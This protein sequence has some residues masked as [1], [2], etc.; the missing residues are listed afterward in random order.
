[1]IQLR[2]CVRDRE[3]IAEALDDSSVEERCK[4]KLMAVRMHYLNLPHSSIAGTLNISDDAVTN[5]LKLYREGGIDALLEN[6]YYQPSSS[7]ESYLD[8][9]R[10][11]LDN[12]PVATTKEGA[13]RIEKLTGIKLSDDQ[14]RR[15]IKRLGLQYR[16]TAAVPEK[17]MD[18]CSLSF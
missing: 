6:R 14:A 2:L 10:E 12:D 9:I 11:S 7:V 1:M 8:T 15:I 4:R 18:R 16:K 3:T 17:L 13:V 5:Y